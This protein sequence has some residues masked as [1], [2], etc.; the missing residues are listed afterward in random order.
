M[1]STAIAT[2]VRKNKGHT[3]KRQITFLRKIYWG[4]IRDKYL[5]KFSTKHDI[6]DFLFRLA[7]FGEKLFTDILV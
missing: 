2:V 6:A 5:E 4:L 7:I 3:N 1:I